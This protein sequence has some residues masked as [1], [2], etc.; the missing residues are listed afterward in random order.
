MP[1][2]L[3]GLHRREALALL[4]GGAAGLTLPR[5]GRAQTAKELRIGYQSSAR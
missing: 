1:V 4:A 5:I 2:T 3:T